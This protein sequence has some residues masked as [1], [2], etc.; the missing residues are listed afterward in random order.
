MGDA[1]RTRRIPRKHLVL[2]ALVLAL[3]RA[4][5]SAQAL[6]LQ[7]GGF[8]SD[9]SAW[10]IASEPGG[11]VQ[12]SAL[13][14]AGS[15]SSGSALL[16]NAIPCAPTGP[17]SY[18]CSSPSL[19]QCVTV[20]PGVLYHLGFAAF[21][22]PGQ[23]STGVVNMLVEWNGGPACAGSPLSHPSIGVGHITA[24]Q[25]ASSS[26]FAPSGARS[27]LVS[28]SALRDEWFIAGDYRVQVDNVSFGPAQP[29]AVPAASPVGLVV[30]G[31]AL[32]AGGWL[33]V[34]RVWS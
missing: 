31:L 6:V 33:L 30:F 16:V 11:S 8:D 28:I 25:S 24:W 21:E 17:G 5:L 7:N 18:T 15:P 10:S 1:G 29:V 14:Y 3:S 32:A 20:S 27:A 2:S 22:P 23:S 4:W 34:D 12:W 9:L 13:D 26:L 19:S